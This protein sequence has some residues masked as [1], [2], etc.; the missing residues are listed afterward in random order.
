MAYQSST[1]GSTASNPPILLTMGAL[2]STGIGSTVASTSG[3]GPM[4]RVWG[5]NSTH[6]QAEVAAAGFITDARKMGMQLGDAVMV[7]GST[8]LVISFHAVQALSSTG[9]TLS[10]GLLVSSAS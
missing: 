2:A 8:T 3:R 4:P 10:A 5:Y 9:A 7:V 6:T 1:V